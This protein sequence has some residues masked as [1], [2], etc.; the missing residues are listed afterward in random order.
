MAT[1]EK[2]DKGKG[3]ERNRQGERKRK[4]RKDMKA[5]RERNRRKGRRKRS[6]VC[7]RGRDGKRKEERKRGD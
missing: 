4:E 1:K 3:E 7:S 6:K 2:K 5:G